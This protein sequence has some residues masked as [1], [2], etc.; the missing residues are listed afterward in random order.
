[1]NYLAIAQIDAAFSTSNLK[2]S[3]SNLEVCSNN[4]LKIVFCQ[5]YKAI[6]WFQMIK[7]LAGVSIS[8]RAR[9]KKDLLTLGFTVT[10]IFK[11]EVS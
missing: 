11:V 4:C 1:M 6:F 8:K 3:D 2:Q 5:V 10:G 7:R 9:Q